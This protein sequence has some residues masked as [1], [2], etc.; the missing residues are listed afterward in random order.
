MINMNNI[1]STWDLINRFDQSMSFEGTANKKHTD[2][3]GPYR[4]VK[5]NNIE[6]LNLL[7][8]NSAFAIDFREFMTEDEGS[9]SIWMSPLEDMEP[10][11]FASSYRS[12]DESSSC[13]NILSDNFQPHKHE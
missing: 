12:I 13:V 1:Q 3:I 4:F 8:L 10:G 11:N 5:W 6:S 2:M 7:S 9:F